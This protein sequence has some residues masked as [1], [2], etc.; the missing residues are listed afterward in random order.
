MKLLLPFA[1][2]LVAIS[3]EGN[4][5]GELSQGGDNVPRSLQMCGMM[6][7]GKSNVVADI[8]T[9]LSWPERTAL[10]VQCSQSSSLFSIVPASCPTSAPPMMTT[11]DPDPGPPTD[12]PATE[13][14]TGRLFDSGPF[15]TCKNAATYQNANKVVKCFSHADCV[16][17]EPKVGNP[18]CMAARC[19][20]GSDA[21]AGGCANF[22][23]ELRITDRDGLFP[24]DPSVTVPTVPFPPVNV[25]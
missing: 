24:I 1:L 15:E 9:F 16:K 17:Y 13:P 6:N 7:G 10:T 3:V 23:P 2:F 19:I 22:G 20:C 12:D 5:R 18:C 14:D 21:N 8:V 4:L 25:P 11:P